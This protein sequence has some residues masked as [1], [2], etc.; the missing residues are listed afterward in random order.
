MLDLGLFPASFSEP[1]TI[2]TFNVLRD[3][4][5][6]NLEM[7]VCSHQ[8]FQKLCRSTNSA[9]PH[10][11]FNRY[12]ELR[13]VSQQWRNLLH[14]RW[15]GFGFRRDPTMGNLLEPQPGSLGWVRGCIVPLYRDWSPPRRIQLPRRCHPQRRSYT[16]FSDVVSRDD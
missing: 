9:F 16:C 12:Q 4:R 15:H 6:S 14:R 7:H 1:K 2:F 11:V 5:L 8:Y 10:K 13:H 3:Y